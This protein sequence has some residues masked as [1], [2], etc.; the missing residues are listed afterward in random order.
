MAVHG[1]CIMYTQ[2]W[3]LQVRDG[4][5]ISVNRIIMPGIL[6][7]N[8][9][10]RYDCIFLRETEILCHPVGVQACGVYQLCCSEDVAFCCLYLIVVNPFF[11]SFT[12]E[13]LHTFLFKLFLYCL[14]HLN[15]IYSCCIR[16][17]ECMVKCF[18]IRVNL[19]QFFL[20]DDLNLNAIRL[21]SL[22]KFKKGGEFRFVFCHDYLFRFV[23]LKSV[24][25]TVLTH[26]SVAVAG[27]FR[28]Q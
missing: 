21:A 9:L 2:E 22:F 4:I 14:I 24:R 6:Q 23:D 28:F 19:R 1:D 7:I 25:V 3:I 12:E 10:E 26:L 15:R 17:Q 8:S 13:K 18:Y 16:G 5:N 20:V 27:E 11:I